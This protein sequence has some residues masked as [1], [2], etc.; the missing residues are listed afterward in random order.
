MSKKTKGIILAG[1]SGTRLYPITQVVSKQLLPVYNKPMIFYPLSLLIHSGIKEILIIT[2]PED[3]KL[4]ARLLSDGKQWDVKIDYA[5]QESPEGIAQAFT[6]ANDWLDNSN[7]V[8]ILGD[9]IFY[10]PQLFDVVSNAI[11]NNN[12]A[13][14]FGFEVDKPEQFGVIEF[15][16]DN[17]VISIEEKPDIPKSN[18]IATG[19]YIYNNNA[20]FI[21]S[22]LSKSE[23]GE[24][25]I[26]DLNKAYMEKNELNVVILDKT[27]SWLDTGT[28]KTLLE[29]SNFAKNRNIKTL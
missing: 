4:F 15:D 22:N 2:T 9:N 19:L 3:K 6:I 23:R 25:E 5:I 11:N 24:Y 1:G 8:L 17:K 21:A 28:H 7:S 14:I 20:P 29:A 18:W 26:T 13:T 12:G 27:Y 16:K 10:G